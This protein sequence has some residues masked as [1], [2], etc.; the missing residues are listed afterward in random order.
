M[1]SGVAVVRLSGGMHRIIMH[2]DWSDPAAQVTGAEVGN[3]HLV[4]I[5]GGR[6]LCAVL[7]LARHQAVL[8]PA[9]R[10][11]LHDA[12][13]LAAL[14]SFRRWLKLQDIDLRKASLR[15][16]EPDCYQAMAVDHQ[17]SPAVLGLPDGALSGLFADW[18][19]CRTMTPLGARII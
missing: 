13:G 8:V 18:L 7:T 10:L 17:F 14:E 16:I 12:D 19:S 6:G 4:Q 9:G 1:S 2:L 3:V 15:S 5:R 11:G